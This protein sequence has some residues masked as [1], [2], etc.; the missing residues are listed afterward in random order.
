MMPAVF[1][2]DTQVAYVKYGIGISANM[3]N[4]VIQEIDIEEMGARKQ[5]YMHPLIELGD[6][7]PGQAT[8]YGY[9]KGKSVR[10]GRCLTMILSDMSRNAFGYQV[11]EVFNPS[12]DVTNEGGIY[13]ANTIIVLSSSEQTASKIYE[14]WAQRLRFIPEYI[15]GRMEQGARDAMQASL[16]AYFDDWDKLKEETDF[17]RFCAVSWEE[18]EEEVLTRRM[19]ELTEK[20][21]PEANAIIRQALRKDDPE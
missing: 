9:S 14:N 1:S 3:I 7:V 20:K 21:R 16:K 8:I 15:Y 10:G 18:R 4:D 6:N 2:K 12:E 19:T 11:G 17:S 13:R 5:M